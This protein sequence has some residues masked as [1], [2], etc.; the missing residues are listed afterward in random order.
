MINFSKNGIEWPFG[1]VSE[2]YTKHNVWHNPFI[3][4]G[5]SSA[6]AKV[7]ETRPYGPVVFIRNGECVNHVINQMG[8]NLRRLV[9]E[10]KEKKLED[11]KGIRGKENLT[12]AKFDAIENFYGRTI[13]D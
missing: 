6:Y 2:I 5:N 9:K 7:N 11:G 4:D 3:G 10:Y 13:R 12:N 1:N 8:S